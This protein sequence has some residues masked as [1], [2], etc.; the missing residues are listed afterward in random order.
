MY[1]ITVRKYYGNKRLFG[2]NVSDP[3]AVPGASTNNNEG[4]SEL[5]KI[6]FD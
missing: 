6:L 1:I 4:G 5:D 3:G 2:I